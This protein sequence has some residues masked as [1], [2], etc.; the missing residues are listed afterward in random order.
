MDDIL[1]SMKAFLYDRS[2]SPL[3]GAFLLAWSAWNY[4]IIGILLS[5]EGFD[6][7]FAGIDRL[8]KTIDIS[9]LQYQIHIPGQIVHGFLIPSIATFAYIYLYPTIAK[10]VY[11][12]S[13]KKQ[14][15]LRSIKQEEENN[16]LLSEEDSRALYNTLSEQ[17]TE[18]YAKEELYRKQ[19]S[20]LTQSLKEF[21]NTPS[22]NVSI[23]NE[24]LS[25][26]EVDKDLPLGGKYSQSQINKFIAGKVELLPNSEFQLSDLLD[27]KVWKELSS[28]NKQ[29]IGKRFKQSVERGDYYGVTL[30][31]K[32]TGNQLIYKKSNLNEPSKNNL[33]HDASKVLQ[34]FIGLNEQE[35]LGVSDL[36]QISD[37][38]IDKIRFHVDRLIKDNYL[39]YFG[40]S[41][42]E[43]R[44]YRL[45][46]NG[47]EYLVENDL[48]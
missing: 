5:N 4:R 22:T 36:K 9:I 44:L 20:S 32:G 13:L 16:R 6:K 37:M 39:E 2:T 17:Q 41:I 33:S 46:N 45:G 26:I 27:D 28:S 7:K 12:H 15:E 19:I 29:A 25:D 30:N 18:F 34:N 38:H 3:F 47:R 14:K 8:Y 35:G 10:P 11:Q 23:Q 21:Q 31:R 24:D 48:V 1:K 40:E 43:E 42:D